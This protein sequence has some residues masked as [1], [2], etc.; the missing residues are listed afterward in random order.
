MEIKNAIYTFDD[1]LNEC[2]KYINNAEDL[3][4][5]KK[6]YLFANEKHSGQLR[7]SGDPYI[8]HCL[9][10]AMI[11]AK[12][13]T[14]PKTIC[15]GLLHDVIED[16]PTKI[17]EV[18]SEFSNEVAQLV[19][20]LT[21]VTRL[22]DYQNVEFTSENHRK[23]FVAMAKD[24]RV[25]LVKL[26][27][28]LH[29]MRTLQYQPPIKQKRIAQETL[30]VYAPIAHRLGLNSFQTEF[31]DTA[32][33]Y[34]D[35]SNYNLIENK[36]NKLTKNLSESIEKIEKQIDEI[37][38]KS[39]IKYTITHRL[40]S[41]YS[42]Y[43]KMFNKNY[44][45]EQIYDFMAL[46]IITE[47]IQNCYEILG[48]L[49][50][51]FKPVPG[52]FKDYIAMPK[53]NMY[54]SL[55]TTVVTA[56][57]N[58]FE[59]Q[60]RTHDMDLLAEGGVAAHW[61]YKEG[62]S[63]DAKKE[64]EE[65]ENQLHWFKEMVSI[66]EN[67]ED[68]SQHD[69]VS[70]LSHDIFDTHV[71]VFTPK[72]NVICLPNGSTPID[73]AFKIHSEI[74]E[75]LSGAKV[76]GILVPISYKLTTGDIVEVITN[77][78]NFPN[79]EWINIAQ[80]SFAKNRI[81]KFLIKQDNEYSKDE[82]IK[83]SRQ[84]LTDYL[85]EKKVKASIEELLDK[86]LLKHFEVETIDDLLL[87]IQ[88]KN[89][90][91]SNIFSHSV[92]Y[93]EIISSRKSSNKTADITKRV[94]KSSGII[95]LPNGD[96]I[97]STL[98]NCCQ[99][100]L[101]DEIV[102]FVTLGQGVKIHRKD[103]PNIHDTNKDRLIEVMWNPNNASGKEF[104]VDL[105]ILSQD[106]QN[107]VSDILNTLNIANAKVT[108]LSAKANYSNQTTKITLTLLAKN[109][110]TLEFFISSIYKVKSIINISRRVR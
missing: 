59:V 77:K 61:R 9:G 13:N 90:N 48:F 5:I 41:I 83:N 56:D 107:L 35:R 70:S 73:F 28:R 87:L 45:F 65:I 108:K 24:V 55:H 20:A 39:N 30:D 89:V 11:L 19:E 34:L 74:G 96:S 72:G 17:E 4:L 50:A 27:D 38:S 58:F 23:I 80:T 76:N 36:L 49:H 46:R 32:L 14:G 79:S 91:P 44:T 10:V 75:H 71:Y 88:K 57:G 78:N 42:I 82:L 25:I 8:T 12:L 15:A 92:K 31:E 94:S 103:C 53:A 63:Y 101:G 100:V 97:M 67:N 52:R 102:G 16:T 106:R 95:C 51:S 68:E 66:V 33:Y 110:E 69:I 64:Q 84:V 1:V 37:L 85:K 99:P 60:I 86:D 54:Q 3:A 2:K 98:A 104:A 26:A 40:K 93:N 43:K 29:N 62:T 22:S 7:K 18:T 105:E 81:R 109:A 47:N 6:A 21:K